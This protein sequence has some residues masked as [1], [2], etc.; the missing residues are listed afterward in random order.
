MGGHGVKK[1]ER[2]KRRRK[3][4]TSSDKCPACETLLSKYRANCLVCGTAVRKFDFY[5]CSGCNLYWPTHM[6][7]SCPKCGGDAK[8]GHMSIYKDAH[9]RDYVFG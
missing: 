8:D 6:G 3:V 1:A 2:P 7:E 9:P 5:I 4:G